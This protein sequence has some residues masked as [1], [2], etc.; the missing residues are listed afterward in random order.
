MS[1]ADAINKAKEFA[2]NIGSIEQLHNENIELKKLNESMK[3]ELESDKKALA[4][5][6][7]SL[8]MERQQSKDALRDVQDRLDKRLDESQAI[9]NQ[10]LS[11][12]VLK[13]SI[14]LSLCLCLLS[15]LTSPF[16]Q[17]Q[18]AWATSYQRRTGLTGSWR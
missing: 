2:E 16:L 1:T 5:A 12:F 14:L 10:L 13:N 9:D 4:Q 17:L 15:N 18:L 6:E 8:E 11:K 3:M 7:Q